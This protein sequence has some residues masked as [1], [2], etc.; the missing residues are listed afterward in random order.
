M[1]AQLE[2]HTKTLATKNDLHGPINAQSRA[3]GVH[4]EQV[5]M[6]CSCTHE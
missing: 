1:L 3:C 4:D 5:P 6:N 2:A